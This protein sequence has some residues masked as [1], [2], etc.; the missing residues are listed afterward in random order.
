MAKKQLT[1]SIGVFVYNEEK[2]ISHLLEALSKQK[3]SL[4]NISEI[5]VVSS[6][7]T[8]N[9]NQIVKNFTKKNRK[10]RLIAQKTREGKASAINLFLRNA[11]NDVV[12]IESGDT[13]PHENC[14]ENLCKPFIKSL[15]LGLTGA[16]SIPTNDKNTCL[17]YII[18]YWWWMHNELPRFGEMIAFRKNIVPQISNKTAVDEADAEAIISNKGYKKMQIPNAIANN[19]GAERFKDLIK[20]RKRVYIGHK[21]L[22]KE[23]N[24]SVQSFN[25]KRLLSLTLKYI[26]QEKSFKGVLYI[27]CGALIEVYSRILGFYDLYFKKKNPYIW[28]IS[29]TTKLVKTNLQ[30][31]GG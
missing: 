14:I 1:V 8:D 23:K 2:N 15:D 17:G 21:I 11:K 4:I 30:N 16:R 18:H 19:H 13:I 7:S 25:S 10:I 27:F 9:T 26:R 3:T 20:Q 24:Y 22:E 28:E 12:V 31:P 29:N 6:G 5:I